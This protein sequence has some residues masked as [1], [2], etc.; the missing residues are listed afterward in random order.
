MHTKG[1]S[2]NDSFTFHP[3]APRAVLLL[4]WAVRVEPVRSWKGLNRQPFPNTRLFLANSKAQG[5]RFS[6]KLQH[7]LFG[8]VRVRK[9]VLGE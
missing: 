3:V 9:N 8:R 7:C 4:S 5:E 6:S 1:D 2:P